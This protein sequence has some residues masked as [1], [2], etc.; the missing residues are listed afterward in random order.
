[1]YPLKIVTQNC[2]VITLVGRYKQTNV[3]NVCNGSLERQWV[4]ATQ[5][6][7]HNLRLEMR[8]YDVRPERC[9]VIAGKNNAWDRLAADFKRLRGL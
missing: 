4:R 3:C 5:A 9:T 8:A 6:V 7:V 2:Y 1:M